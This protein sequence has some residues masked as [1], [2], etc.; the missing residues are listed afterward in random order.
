MRGLIAQEGSVPGGF[1]WFPAPR[2][3]LPALLVLALLAGVGGLASMRGPS[4]ADTTASAAAIQDRWGIRVS[5][6][7]VTADG[8]FVDFRYVVTDPDKALA[9]VSD[10]KNLPSIVATD[11]AGTLNATA[12]MGKPHALI[13]G[14]TYFL[15]FWNKGHAVQ[16][17]S[18]A[19]VELGDLRLDNVD[20]R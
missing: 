6:V 16:S 4:S 2:I 18:T 11:G 19:A 10:P 5:Q 15:L 20:V 17:G 12:L 13:A 14:H 3:V 7:A 1:R 9:M 8:G